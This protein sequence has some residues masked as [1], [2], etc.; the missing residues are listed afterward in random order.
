M[1]WRPFL[2]FSLLAA[3]LQGYE[4]PEGGRD[5]LPPRP[6]DWRFGSQP[7]AEAQGTVVKVDGQA[8]QEAWRISIAR[9]PAVSYGVTLHGALSG[10]VRRG[11]VLLLSFHLRARSS[12]NESGTVRAKLIVQR[13]QP[14]HSQ[15]GSAAVEAGPAWEHFVFPLRAEQTLPL[16]GGNVSIHLGF[17]AQ[18][19]E[20][21][22]LRLIHYG[23][24]RDPMTLPQTRGRYPGQETDAGWRAA[25]SRRIE[26]IRQG[27]LQLLVTDPEGQPLRG[28]QVT[29]TMKR[30]AF[31]FGCVVNPRAY[32]QTG[33]DGSRYR[34]Y[35]HRYFNKVP[36]ENGFRW[37][38]WFPARRASSPSDL[39]ELDRTLDGL[40]AQDIEVRG[41]Y[42]MW[43]PLSSKTQPAALLDDAPALREALFDHDR[44]KSRFAGK[45]VGEWDAVNHI[46]GWGRTYAD[47]LGREIYGEVIRLGKELNP[48]AEMWINEGQVLPGGSRRDPYYDMAEFLLASGAP[49]DGIGFMGHFTSGSLTGIDELNRVLDR[50]A[51]L[52]R[53][54]QLTEFDV[55]VG[56]DQQLQ[57][58]YLSDVMTLCFSHPAVEAVVMWGFW[59]GRHWKPNAAL[60]RRDWSIKPAG[61]RWLDLVFD[62]WWTETEG[63][64]DA[65]GRVRIRGYLGDYEIKVH[66]AG[67]HQTL[68]VTLTREGIEIPVQL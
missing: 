21:A 68:K 7:E 33:A 39:E 14:P 34:E 22:D 3:T 26:K 65:S 41:H 19:L 2:L 11:D 55:D 44:E 12:E 28:A 9:K 62:R 54:L 67:R 32:T 35:V 16:R 52:G 50:F 36:M 66:H 31:G 37:Q 60:W 18:D 20:L 38:N 25:A 24:E 61:Q 47:L 4:I 58:D 5:L 56:F 17:G 1:G 53:P 10:P 59:E 45:R 57:A 8:F 64:T 42:L 51:R 23:P 43:A 6:G 13:N 15:A 49:L 40:R 46:I 30:H 29:V 48:H 63:T 27:D